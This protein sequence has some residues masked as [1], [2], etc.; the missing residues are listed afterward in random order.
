MGAAGSRKAA[1]AIRA[2]AI[3]NLGARMRLGQ[4]PEMTRTFSPTQAL[5]GA[6]Q[7]VKPY[8]LRDML[9]NQ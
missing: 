3:E 6:Q 1:E 2:N 8:R 9:P 7:G 5:I 4:A